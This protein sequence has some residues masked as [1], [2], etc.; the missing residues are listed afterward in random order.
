M[1]F[2]H[3][4]QKQHLPIQSST[5]PAAKQLHDPDELTPLYIRVT[6]IGNKGVAPRDML[7]WDDSLFEQML[8]R[9]L[10]VV[11]DKRLNKRPISTTATSANFVG[12][13]DVNTA[14]AI[15]RVAPSSTQKALIQYL[16]F[17]TSGPRYWRPPV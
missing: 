3:V 4:Q 10:L 13:G 2:C 6:S 16:I 12:L 17:M 8:L 14:T 5:S 9:L 11:S 7:E 1:F 15:R